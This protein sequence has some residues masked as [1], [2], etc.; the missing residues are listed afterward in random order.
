MARIRGSVHKSVGFE[1][2]DTDFIGDFQDAVEEFEKDANRALEA[3][4]ES[5]AADMRRR[6]G[7]DHE[8]AASITVTKI[9]DG[10]EVGTSN[11]RGIWTEFGTGIFNPKRRRPIVPKAGRKLLGGGLRH[12]VKEVA[13]MHPH[14]FFRPALQLAIRRFRAA[15]K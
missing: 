10:F 7:N 3:T 2:D 11:H 8:L 13:G 6:L 14:P 12:P 4:A 1:F 5:A 9:P 15:F